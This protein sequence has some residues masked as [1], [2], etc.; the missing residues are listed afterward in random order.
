[1]ANNDWELVVAK[2]GHEGR[3]ALPLN[4]F[5]QVYLLGDG[6]GG[7]LSREFAREQCYDWSHVRDSSPEAVSRMANALREAGFGEPS[8]TVLVRHK[9]GLV[10]FE[11]SREQAQGMGIKVPS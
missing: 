2:M 9:G 10:V 4:V 6:F 3:S 7:G 5:E 8:D 11:V 1:M